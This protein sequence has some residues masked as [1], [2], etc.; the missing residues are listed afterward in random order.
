MNNLVRVLRE[1]RDWSQADL[2]RDLG[3]SRM[4]IHALETGKTVPSMMA[5]IRLAW[6]FGKPIEE[7]FTVDL[8]EKI[9]ICVFHY[10]KRTALAGIPTGADRTSLLR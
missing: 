1:D 3:V 4:A 2:A 10:F 5:A 9:W 7:I 6:Q 8:E